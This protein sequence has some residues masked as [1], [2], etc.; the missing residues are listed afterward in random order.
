MLCRLL[1]RLG[2]LDAGTVAA[3]ISLPRV[4]GDENVTDSARGAIFT[5]ELSHGAYFSDP[6]Y[7]AY[8]ERRAP[9]HARG[10]RQSRTRP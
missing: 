3:V 7:A 10:R 4:G 9:A 5:H 1:Q 8:V 2:W 6:A